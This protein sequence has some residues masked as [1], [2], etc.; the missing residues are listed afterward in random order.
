M[1]KELDLMRDFNIAASILSAD[2]ANLG[3]DVKNV[4]EAGADFVHFDVMDN[5]FVPTL[6]TGP[7]VCSALRDYGITAPID[8]H[9]MTKPVDSLIV[10]F[11]KAGA[12]Y[13]TIHPEAT[14]HLDR[15]LQMIRDL[16]CKAG[17]AFN[18]ATPLE[19]LEYVLERLDMILI[20]SVNPGFGGQTFI[21]YSLKKI[22][23]AHHIIQKSGLPIRLEVDGGVKVDNIGQ[24]AKEGADTF[25]LGTGIFHTEN[26]HT[27]IAQLRA[28][29]NRTT[30]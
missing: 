5:H 18:P 15:S 19:Y 16:G 3:Q 7:L 4:I 17:L 1:T 24:I 29:L 20:M 13:I 30:H 11:A 12:T 8:V 27:T 6:T 23:Q 9:L 14:S 25:V 10:D 26:Y 21:P 2:F 22:Q 28:E